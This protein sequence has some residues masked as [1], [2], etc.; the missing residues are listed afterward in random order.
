MGADAVPEPSSFL[1]G[2]FAVVGLLATGRR[3]RR[4]G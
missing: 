3:R 1:L 2:L 4:A